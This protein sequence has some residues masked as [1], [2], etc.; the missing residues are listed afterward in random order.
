MG[1]VLVTA[2]EL[3]KIL[4]EQNKRTDEQAARHKKESIDRKFKSRVEG[5]E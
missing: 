3:I 5:F 2:A 1:D 4:E